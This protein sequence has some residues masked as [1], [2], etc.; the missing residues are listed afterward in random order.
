LIEARR[1][2]AMTIAVKSRRRNENVYTSPFDALPRALVTPE[3]VKATRKLLGWSQDALAG[4]VGV[5]ASTI[6][7][8][9]IGSKPTSDWIVRAIQ[10]TLEAAGAKFIS[11]EPRVKAEAPVHVALEQRKAAS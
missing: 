1:E 5:A 11:N 6:G 2:A 7:N 3:Q 9:E 10:A 8:F 4:H